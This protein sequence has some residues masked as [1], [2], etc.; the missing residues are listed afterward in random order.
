LTAN[1][2]HGRANHRA[3]TARQRQVLDLVVRGLGNKAI[4]T[5]LAISEQAVKEHVSNLL[6][7]FEVSGRASLAE[8]GTRLQIMGVT[9]ADTS[10]LPYLFIAAPIGVQVFRGP[11]HRIVA[12][13]EAA[14]KAADRDVIGLTLREG[15]PLTADRIGPLLDGVFATGEPHIEY[16]FSG[17][18]VRD[19]QTQASYSDFVLQPIKGVDGTVTDVVLF[20]SDVTERVMAR[21]RAEELG[22]EQLAI[23]DLM[24]DGVIVADATGAVVKVNQAARDIAGTPIDFDQPVSERVATFQIRYAD[25]RPVDFHDL[26][27]IRALAG[28]TV[29]WGDYLMFNRTRRSDVPVR[30]AAK[31]MR[32]REGSIVGAVLVFRLVRRG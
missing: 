4:A 24:N 3:L 31:P 1:R 6:R 30:V 14:R 26:P 13:N 21:R 29:P 15:Y 22:A 5:E 19:G 18:W 12:T 20:G 32:S 2:P 17:T 25:G 8:L 9:D 27:L 7:R 23:F 11:D 10:W 16:E 28:E